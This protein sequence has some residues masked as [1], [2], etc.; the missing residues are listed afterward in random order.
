MFCVWLPCWFAKVSVL[1]RGSEIFGRR[2]CQTTIDDC[3]SDAKTGSEY[4]TAEGVLNDGTR[5]DAHFHVTLV[6]TL[7]YYPGASFAEDS[8]TAAL[9]NPELSLGRRSPPLQ[10][11]GEWLASVSLVYTAIVARHLLQ[12]V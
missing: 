1:N 9:S 5:F 6:D 2:I 11:F 8:G 10:F 3:P 4:P 12:P 7:I